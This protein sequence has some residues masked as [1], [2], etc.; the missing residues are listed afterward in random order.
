MTIS[1]KYYICICLIIIASIRTFNNLNILENKIKSNLINENFFVIDSKN[2][3]EVKSHFYGFGISKKGILTN[4]Y[5]KINGYDNDLNI[6]GVFIMLNKLEN[7]IKISQDY[8]GN[9]GLY[10]FENKDT[11]YFAI[12]NSF[13]L[14]KEHLD[15]TYKLSLNKDFVY[16]LIS[17]DL[18]THSIHETMVNEIR[19]L[20]SNTYIILDIKKREINIHY[21]KRTEKIIP[22]ESKKGLK[23]I[24]KWVDKWCYIIR[25]LINKTNSIIFDISGGFDTRSLLSILLNCGIDL[26]KVTFNSI[27]DHKSCHDEDFQ[28]AKN[29]S[30][31]IGFK[32]NNFS[33]DSKYVRWNKKDSLSSIFYTKLGFHKGLSFHNGFYIKPRFSFTGGGGELIRGYPNYPIYE[34]IKKIS[35]EAKEIKNLS[36]IF[37]DSSFKLINR[38]VNLLKKDKIYEND[39]DIAADLYNK[40]ANSIHFGRSSLIGFLKNW[41][42]IQILVDPDLQ[43]IKYDINGTNTSQDILAYIY[44]RFAPELLNIPFERNRKINDL[45][46]KKAFKLN[47]LMPPYQVKFDFNTNFYIDIERKTPVDFSNDNDDENYLIS[48]LNSKKFSRGF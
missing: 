3:E 35:S 39:Y 34:Y 10:I 45:S 2:L 13:L 37:Y 12:S 22:F 27:N 14:L 24:D 33:F 19:R 30:N 28:I 26:N 44:T 11:N 36:Q 16:N 43:Q 9:Y 21:I 18:H 41:Y 40:G 42:S 46:R 15:R 25:S 47:K 38:S 48:F 32:L 8:Y 7:Y 31:K 6:Y 17:F 4:N 5:F 29:I 1:L 20:E 23:I